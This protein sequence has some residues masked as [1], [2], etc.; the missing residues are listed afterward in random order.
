MKKL[1]LLIL[2]GLFSVSSYAKLNNVYID[3]SLLCKHLFTQNEYNEINP[4]LGLSGFLSDDLELRFGYYNNS[5]SRPTFYFAA[6]YIPFSMNVK[7]FDI[8]AGVAFGL[9][10]GY[11]TGDIA[12]GNNNL[13]FGNNFVPVFAPSV[14]VSFKSIKS[15]AILLL[16]GNALCLQVS[17]QIF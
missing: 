16:L 5:Y 12:I 11:K 9:A 17:Y 2:A 6:N 1:F 4:G 7:S 15:R 8:N 14:S 13:V 10:T 3:A